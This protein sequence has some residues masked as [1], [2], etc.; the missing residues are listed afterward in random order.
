[1][2]TAVSHFDQLLLLDEIRTAVT[3]EVK[4]RIG[5]CIDIAQNASRL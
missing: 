3:E 2:A 1:M 5:K 4:K